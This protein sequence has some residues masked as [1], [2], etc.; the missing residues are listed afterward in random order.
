MRSEDQLKILAQ[1]LSFQNTRSF[2]NKVLF[3]VHVFFNT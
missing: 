2:Y 1:K 3:P